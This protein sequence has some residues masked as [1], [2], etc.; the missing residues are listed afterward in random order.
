MTSNTKGFT[1]IESTV[2]LAIAVFVI[3]M[4]YGYIKA[5]PLFF[6]RIQVQQQTMSEART[7][8]DT[9]NRLLRSALPNT[10]AICSCNQRLCGDPLC[11]PATSIPPNSQIDFSTKDG[12]QRWL[13]WGSDHILYAGDNSMNGTPP[14][15][16]KLAQNVASVMFT[17]DY[18]DLSVINVS[19]R[20]D[21]PLDSSGA[22]NAPTMTIFLPT[23]SIR[24]VS[25][26]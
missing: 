6:R 1:I 26:Q 13:I 9:M 15:T 14:N 4:L 21:V 7:A 23:Q 3:M 10:V 18:R 12:H 25:A 16:T 5:I 2:A 22:P 24:M 20:F 8:A 17:G 11:I 19:L